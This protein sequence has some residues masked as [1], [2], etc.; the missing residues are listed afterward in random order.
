MKNYLNR[1]AAL[2]LALMLSVSVP[3]AV[4]AEEATEDANV[5][6]EN[7]I[8]PEV[9]EPAAAAEE[10]AIE[11]PAVVASV[12]ISCQNLGSCEYFGDRLFLKADIKNGDGSESVSWQVNE[13]YASGSGNWAHAGNGATLS[14]TI[15]PAIA[16]YGYRCV[17]STGA[18]SSVF[19]VDKSFSERP[20]EP[21]TVE[22]EPVAEEKAPE[23]AAPA[24][25]VKEEPVQVE[26]VKTEEKVEEVK[27]EEKIE[28]VKTEEKVEEVKTEEK[29]EEV[30]TEE[31][32]EEVKA[33]EKVEEV[34]AEEKVEEVK[35]EEKVE[36]VKTEEKVEEVKAEEKVEEEQPAVEAIDVIETE[37]EAESNND[38]EVL[39]EEEIEFDDEEVLEFD[40]DDWGTTESDL[41]T[42]FDDLANSYV[43]ESEE[44]AEDNTINEELPEENIEEIISEDNTNAEIDNNKTDK[45]TSENVTAEEI[46]EENT[47][48]ITEENTADEETLEETINEGTLEGTTDNK[49]PEEIIGEEIPKENID[50]EILQESTDEVTLEVNTDDITEAENVN[51]EIRDEGI[52]DTEIAEVISEENIDE[53]VPDEIVDE[54]ISEKENVSLSTEEVDVASIEEK[55]EIEQETVAEET[56]E[57]TIEPEAESASTEGMKQMLLVLRKGETGTNLYVAPSDGAA[58]LSFISAGSEIYLAQFDANWSQVVVN[59]IKGYVKNEYLAMFD[60]GDMTEEE[61]EVFRS[62]SIHNPLAGMQYIAEGTPVTMAVVLTGFEDIEYSVQ[63]SYSADGTTFVEIAG[64]RDLTYT[65]TVNKQNV[66]YYWSVEINTLEEE[67]DANE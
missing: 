66:G 48:E 49:I 54:M 32:V 27:T 23:T 55:I 67:M 52:A 22:A 39:P 45:V 65:Y 17:L 50:E 33:E 7:I 28:E 10:P 14:V 64:A 57:E 13:N 16:Q 12:R 63:W 43:E 44:T 31:K 8:L 29:V 62:V 53:I 19:V 34:K 59:D 40:D 30:K 60:H 4:G 2:T 58:V 1:I 41:F 15:T 46:T 21:A 9:E 47:D 6:A 18:M 35:A 26:E 42:A 61:K 37:V 56:V 38:D 25:P 51:E 3:F 24:E 20:V 11:V 36:E 5:Q